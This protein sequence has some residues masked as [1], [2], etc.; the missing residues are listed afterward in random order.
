MQAAKYVPQFVRKLSKRIQKQDITKL[1]K[2][3]QCYWLKDFMMNLDGSQNLK[4]EGFQ[5]RRAMSYT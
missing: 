4:V 3:R 2:C 5:P 1:L